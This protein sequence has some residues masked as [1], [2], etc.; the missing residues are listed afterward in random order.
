MSIGQVRSLSAAEYRGWQLFNVIEPWGFPDQEYRTAALLAKLHNVNAGK[1]KGKKL[2]FFMRDLPKAALN[3]LREKSWE[4]Q[5]EKRTKLE[6]MSMDEKKNFFVN[7]FK[8]I[9]I[10]ARKK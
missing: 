3:Y 9:G 7:M 4:A 1:R 6:Q 10:K 8:G 5:E 2:E